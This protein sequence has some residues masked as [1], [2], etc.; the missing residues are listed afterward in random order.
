MGRQAH[1]TATSRFT[2]S[3]GIK[4]NGIGRGEQLGHVQIETG[5]GKR[6]ID[7]AS[8]NAEVLIQSRQLFIIS[9]TCRSARDH[10][11]SCCFEKSTYVPRCKSIAAVHQNIKPQPLANAVVSS[12]HDQPESF[13]H[14]RW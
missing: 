1:A 6:G 11:V 8:L 9:I 4:A 2:A 10:D 12:L 13:Y 3:L 14:E 7:E 5:L